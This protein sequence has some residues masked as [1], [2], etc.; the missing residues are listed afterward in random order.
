MRHWTVLYGYDESLELS[1]GPG[2]RA[3]REELVASSKVRL[4]RYLPETELGQLPVIP[5]VVSTDTVRTLP[6]DAR[7]HEQAVRRDSPTVGPTPPGHGGKRVRHDG[8]RPGRPRRRV[9]R[10]SRRPRVRPQRDETY[11][12]QERQHRSLQ[13]TVRIPE[14]VREDDIEATM[15]NGVLTV[16]LPKAEPDDS[17]TSIDI[18]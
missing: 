10:H 12:R 11:L 5:D 4:C 6:T 18:L 13:E 14:R 7:A 2:L 17:G 16:T 1:A 15:Q 3:R 9:R 8:H